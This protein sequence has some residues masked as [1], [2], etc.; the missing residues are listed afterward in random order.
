MFKDL[1][2]VMATVRSLTQDQLS[3]VVIGAAALLVTGDIT[4][5]QFEFVLN[6]VLAVMAERELAEG[7]TV[8]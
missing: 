3:Q 7:A 4:D 5:D 2:E 8:N 6:T 1:D